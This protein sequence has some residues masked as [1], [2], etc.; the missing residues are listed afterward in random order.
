MQWKTFHFPIPFSNFIFKIHFQISFSNFIFK[1]HFQYSIRL[2]HEFWRI[3]SMPSPQKCTL[4]KL[5]FDDFS[6]EKADLCWLLADVQLA[7]ADFCWLLL[8]EGWLW[9]TFADFYWAKVDCPWLLL[10]ESWLWLTFSD[11]ARGKVGF[12]LT[13]TSRKLTLAV[14]FWLF[15]NF[16]LALY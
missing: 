14:F 7:K 2:F 1:F 3:F 9:L 16:L 11:S 15:A 12:S 5:P 6:L 8:S 10:S 13:F 4:L